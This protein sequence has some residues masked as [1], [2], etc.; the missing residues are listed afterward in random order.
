MIPGSKEL[1]TKFSG[2]E[3][4]RAG[5]R[6]ILNPNKSRAFSLEEHRTRMA[7]VWSDFEKYR[8]VLR[9][10]TRRVELLENI[11]KEASDG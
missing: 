3:D 6:A 1:E 2:K 11:R 7:L 5:G 10:L 4:T 8:E 9:E